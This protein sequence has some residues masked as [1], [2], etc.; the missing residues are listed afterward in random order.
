MSRL[1]VSIRAYL[2]RRRFERLTSGY[3]LAIASARRSHRNVRALQQA[4]TDYL[5]AA[6]RRVPNIGE[7]AR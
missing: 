6:L 4:K 7:G 3:D 2:I 5:H 1:F